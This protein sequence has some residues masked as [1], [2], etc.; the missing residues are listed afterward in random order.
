MHIMKEK[1]EFIIAQFNAVVGDIEGNLEKIIDIIDKNRKL[2][3][4]KVFVFPELAL[5]GYS[6]EDLLF[7]EDFSVKIN[8]SIT[9]IQNYIKSNEFAVGTLVQHD[10]FGE[11]KVLGINGKKLQVKFKK[12]EEIMSIF[13]DFVKKQ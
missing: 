13:S 11:G 10:D 7:R 1:I 3:A 8:K 4:P 5:C 6:P 2:N 12:F 9:K